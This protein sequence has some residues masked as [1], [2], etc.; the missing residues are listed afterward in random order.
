[1]KYKFE[2]DELVNF[3]NK[4]NAVSVLLTCKREAIYSPSIYSWSINYREGVLNCKILEAFR[5]R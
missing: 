5:A 1:M 3:W 2:P 4:A